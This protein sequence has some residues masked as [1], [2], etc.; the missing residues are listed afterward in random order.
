MKRNT[1]YSFSYKK[2]YKKKIIVKKRERERFGEGDHDSNSRSEE[3][4]EERRWWNDPIGYAISL[5]TWNI[6]SS[7]ANYPID[8]NSCFRVLFYAIAE[9]PTWNM[10]IKGC[11]QGG[12]E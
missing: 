9:S 5:I 1:L 6:H 12:E 8:I 10:M 7:C 11:L 4:E 2:R 3:G